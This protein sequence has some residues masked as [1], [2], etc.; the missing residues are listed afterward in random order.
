[1]LARSRGAARTGAGEASGRRR[2]RQIRMS[3]PA[4]G[5]RAGT[6]PMIRRD[7]LLNGT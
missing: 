1:M 4:V 6:D 3:N 2:K 5:S 7:I